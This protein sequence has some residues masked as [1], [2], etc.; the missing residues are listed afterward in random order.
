MGLLSFAIWTPI[1]FGVIL[2]AFGRDEHAKV[3]RWFALI[4]ALVSLAVT[5][6]L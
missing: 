5:V 2:L 3:V 4:G 1:I 6:P